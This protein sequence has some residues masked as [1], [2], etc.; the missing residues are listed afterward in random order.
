MIAAQSG[1]LRQQRSLDIK[2]ISNLDRAARYLL[3]KALSRCRS[4]HLTIEDADELWSTPGRGEPDAVLFVNNPRFYRRAILGGSLAA[5]ASYIDGD[6]QCHD[7][8]SL[9]RF[10]IANE[11]PADKLDGGFAS[12]AAAIA[13]L[14]HTRRSNSKTGS[15]RNIY[16]HYDLGNEMFELFLDQTMTYSS[17]VFPSQSVTLEQAQIEKLELICRKLEL[18]DKDHVIEIGTGWGSFAIHAAKHYGCRVTTTTISEQQAQL[19]K[20]KFQQHGVDHLIELQITDYRDLSGKYDKLVSIEMIEAVGHEFLP[21][22]F[23]QCSKLL[24]PGGVML[25][26]AITM[27]GNRYEQYLKNSDFIREYIFPGSCCP[28][29]E[30]CL[31]A[32]ESTGDLKINDAHNI[33]PHYATTLSR[34]YRKFIGKREALIEMGYDDAFIRTWAY[35]FCYCEAGFK[36]RYLG[37]YQLLLEKHS[38]VNTGKGQ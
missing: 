31:G 22:Y 20:E 35:Y 10:F 37:N 32:I 23:R 38:A 33:G 2:P 34:W 7:L 15:K 18:S 13:R 17:A 25:I 8:T 26:Q 29:L 14:R 30:A 4:G 3:R 1:I 16:A 19:A 24:K 12:I 36:N 5:A 6:W 11:T 27:P 9:F 21:V 28:S